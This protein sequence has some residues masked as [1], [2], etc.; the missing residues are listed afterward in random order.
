MGCNGA[1]FGAEVRG[2]YWKAGASRNRPANGNLPRAAVMAG[3]DGP[4]LHPCPYGSRRLLPLLYRGNCCDGD[5]VTPERSLNGYRFPGVVGK[6]VLWDHLENVA[7]RNQDVLR[8][9]CDALGNTM[10]GLVA[11]RAVLG[12]AIAVAHHPSPG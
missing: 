4:W 5:G 7:A 2:E 10:R 3:L 12:S 1:G 11:R 6:L 9:P 8:S